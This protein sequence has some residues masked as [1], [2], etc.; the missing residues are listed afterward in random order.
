[1]VSDTPPPSVPLHSRE[2]ILEEMQTLLGAR[3]G[4]TAG[5]AASLWCLNSPL[6]TGGEL[7]RDDLNTAFAIL[8]GFPD[9][10][11]IRQAISCALRGMEIIP[12]GHVPG[13]KSYEGICPEW[14]VDIF[15][16]ACSAYPS[17]TW[18]DYLWSLPL[19]TVCHMVA[20]AHR[21]HGT[22]TARPEDES[23]AEAW[24]LSRANRQKN[25]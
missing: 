6:I 4:I 24:L 11:S 15:R 5:Q 9:E 22:V 12:S 25:K 1:M 23:R 19:C 21:A 14:L 20:S 17:L 16:M 8:P 7:S 3:S 18:E 13:R 2:M 10:L